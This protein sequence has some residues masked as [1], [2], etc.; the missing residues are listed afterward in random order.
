MGFSTSAKHI[1]RIL[2]G[3][4][5][6]LWII[7]GSMDTVHLNNTSLPIHE[8]EMY[9]HLFMSSLISFSNVLEFS[10]YKSFTFLVNFVLSD[11]IGNGNVHVISFSNSSLLV[12]RNANDFCVLILYPATL[13]NLL[14]SSSIFYEIFRVFYM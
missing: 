10:L 8:H 5:L 7:V 14:I 9:F 2:K 3:V 1:A 6:S 11:V 12:Y 13:L 4:G